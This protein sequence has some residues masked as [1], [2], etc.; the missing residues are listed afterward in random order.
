MRNLEQRENGEKGEKQRERESIS[1]A[2]EGRVT[3]KR[4]RENPSK[5]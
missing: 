2:F 3:S 5:K 1:E 4:R